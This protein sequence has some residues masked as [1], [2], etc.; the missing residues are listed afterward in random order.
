MPGQATGRWVALTVGLVTGQ[1]HPL[2][3]EGQSPGQGPMARVEIQ[4]V[5]LGTVREGTVTEAVFLVENEGTEDLIIEDISVSCGCTTVDLPA[6]Q[7]RVGPQGRRKIVVSF[8]S[9]DRIGAQRKTI[10]LSVNDP[11]H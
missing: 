3:D 1:V 10:V 5:D 7:R 9:T 4:T 2:I 8:D 11:A 6:D